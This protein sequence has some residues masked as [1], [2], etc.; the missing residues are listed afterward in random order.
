MFFPILHVLNKTLEINEKV[1]KNQGG[2]HTKLLISH[3]LSAIEY[4]TL[5]QFNAYGKYFY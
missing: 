3:L 2:V 1:R 5:Y 4:Q